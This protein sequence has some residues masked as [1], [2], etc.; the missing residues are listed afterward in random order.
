MLKN[1]ILRKCN[2]SVVEIKAAQ[3]KCQVLKQRSVAMI[4]SKINNMI[5]GKCRH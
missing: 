4:K 1:H 2:P 5:L 3:E